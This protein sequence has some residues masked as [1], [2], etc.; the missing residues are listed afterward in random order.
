MSGRPSFASGGKIGGRAKRAWIC[1]ICG[2]WFDAKPAKQTQCRGSGVKAHMTTA[3]HFP[4]QAEAGHYMELRLLQR[5]GKIINLECQ[6]SFELSVNGVLLGKYIADFQYFDTRTGRTV[7]ADIKGGAQTEIS[8]F[9]RRLAGALNRITI[10]I[11][12]R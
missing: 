12:R 6:P 11:V 3:Q 1:T 9:K 2:A 7:Y 5:A 8:D 4:S 10:N